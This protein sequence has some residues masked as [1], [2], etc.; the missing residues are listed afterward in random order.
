[1]EE[2]AYLSPER[3]DAAH[4]AIPIG[5]IPPFGEIVTAEMRRKRFPHEKK[6][7]KLTMESMWSDLEQGC[8]MMC[9]TSSIGDDGRVDPTPTGMVVKK[10]PDRTLS[11]KMRMISDLR[12]VNI[13]TNSRR[14]YRMTAP[15]IQ[16]LRGEIERLKRAFPGAHIKM[17]KRD[18]SRAFKWLLLRPDMASVLMREFENEASS[19]SADFYA[20]FLALPFGFVGSPGYFCM[21]TDIVQAMRRSFAPS[22]QTWNSN[23]PYE[24]EM[25]VI[26]AMFIEPDIGS[27][28]VESVSGW[29]WA[30]VLMLGEESLGRTKLDIEGT[31]ESRQPMIGFGRDTEAFAIS[32]PQ[33]KN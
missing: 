20:S 27:R 8:M 5:I 10:N 14:M 24:A 4:E 15:T 22:D 6:R 1:M 12:G 13:T 16:K 33:A 3:A 11:G 7:T 17:T 28:L 30:C 21:L 25:F 9:R 31:W 2:K 26:D 18:I 23:F 32:L 19:T 29:K